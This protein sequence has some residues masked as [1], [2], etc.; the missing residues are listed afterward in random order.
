ML[1]CSLGRTRVLWVSLEFSHKNSGAPV[2]FFCLLSVLLIHFDFNFM[3]CVAHMVLFWP[4]RFCFQH[5]GNN[6]NAGHI[7]RGLCWGLVKGRVGCYGR[8]NCSCWKRSWV[9]S[10]RSQTGHKWHTH[11]H[12][13]IDTFSLQYRVVVVLRQV[14]YIQRVTETCGGVWPE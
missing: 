13:H 12:M 2:P 7:L 4:A 11:I 8:I 10:I 9:E 14:L 1:P 6:R 5:S 3:F